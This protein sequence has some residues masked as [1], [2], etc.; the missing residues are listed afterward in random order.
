DARH[1]AA[2][3]ALAL[4]R[5]LI[6]VG[7]FTEAIA[8]LTEA[9]QRGASGPE[10]TGLLRAARVGEALSLGNRLYQDRQ[11]ATALFQFKK[12]LRLDPD[13][14]D[15]LQKISYSQNFL[16]DTQLNDRFTRL[17]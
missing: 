11:Y 4:G 13:N 3:G 14:A 9:Q 2:E 1:A 16:Q 8:A 6:A 15:A 12:A 10:V 7:S 17:E 5:S